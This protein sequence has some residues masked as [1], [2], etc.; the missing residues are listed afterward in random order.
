MSITEF[1]ALAMA[2]VGCL[3]T[4]LG[5]VGLVRM[6]DV[7]MRMSTSAKA[8]T[9]GVALVVLASAVL[10]QELSVTVR[11]LFVVA[12]IFLTVPVASHLIG[13]AAY[14]SGVKLW[15]ATGSDDLAGKY[16]RVSK[17]LKG[18]EEDHKS[19]KQEK[20]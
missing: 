4:L 18:V 1:V 8:S 17:E 13:R 9:M 10:Y 2:T 3:F 15:S 7:Y 20:S 6:P 14:V 5:A 11:A 16:D 19:G 12:F